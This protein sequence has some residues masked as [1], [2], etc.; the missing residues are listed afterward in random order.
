MGGASVS[1][2]AGRL[3]SPCLLQHKLPR[4]EFL[5]LAASLGTS[6]CANTLFSLCPIQEHALAQRM[7]EQLQN[8]E[9]ERAMLHAQIAALT[10]GDV[11]YEDPM[12]QMEV[13]PV[14]HAT[15]GSHWS[16]ARF[17]AGIRV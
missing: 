12:F 16:G 2:G 5:V 15:Q 6:L 4:V 1:A 11:Q 8:A 9:V 17:P 7:A 10:M 3:T 13:N 14:C